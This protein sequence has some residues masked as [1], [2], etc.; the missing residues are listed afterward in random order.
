MPHSITP[1]IPNGASR[2]LPLPLNLIALIISH[3]EAP[4]DLARICRTC[5][6]FH[7]M[8]LPL[9]YNNV[10]LRSYDVIRYSPHDGRPE[11]CGMGSPFVMGLN[12]LVLRNVAEY[13]QVLKLV[14]EFK[15]HDVEECSRIG[16]VPDSSIMLSTLARVIVDRC[17]SLKELCWELNTKML[18]SVWESLVHSRIQSLTIKFPTSRTPKPVTI[19]PP[20]PSLI[21]L[22][23]LDIDP[24][25]YADDVSRLLAESRKLEDLT[26]VWNPRMREASELSVNLGTM[27]GRCRDQPLKLKKAVVKNLFT[28]DDG[29][30]PSYYDTNLVE[31]ITVINSI[32]SPGDTGASPFVEGPM[33]KLGPP[34]PRLK[35]LRGDK[36]W[37]G[38]AE[39]L[40]N[41]GQLEKLYM[42]SPH[43]ASPREFRADLLRDGLIEAITQHHGQTL[44]HLLFPSRWRLSWEHI[45]RITRQCPNLQQLGFA[46]TPSDFM[47]IKS[48]LHLLPKLKVLRLLEY[49]YSNPLS[50][51]WHDYESFDDADNIDTF[52]KDVDPDYLP[53]WVDFGDG[54]VYEIEK[55][56]IP[57]EPDRKTRV[58]Q[59]DS[60]AVKDIDIWR[61]DSFDV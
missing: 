2:L 56:R 3:L 60:D 1:Q 42:P 48:E 32:T 50:E 40:S 15:E 7:Y 24:L 14:G 26:I 16:R 61:L 23:I 53:R 37:E 25:C 49:P 5:R 18:P 34:L 44:R 21:S 36:P 33:R 19:V 4:A 55:V 12:R 28:H 30:C 13:V 9:L 27:F 10:T 22:K 54:P 8:T 52:V 58:K 11:G 46:A 17:I 39:V 38:M 45:K 31:E 47:G 35:Y 41:T 59:R 57:D 29:T 20:I 43:K 6:V 51:Q